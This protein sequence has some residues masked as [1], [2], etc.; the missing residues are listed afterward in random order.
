MV[1]AAVVAARDGAQSPIDSASVEFLALYTHNSTLACC[2][3]GV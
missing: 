2:P 1:V 3:C